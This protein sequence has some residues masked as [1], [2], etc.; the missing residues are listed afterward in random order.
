MEKISIEA[1][2]SSLK[3]DMSSQ[4]FTYND[5]KAEKNLCRI[6]IAVAEEE[7]PITK[8]EDFIKEQKLNEGLAHDCNLIVRSGARCIEEYIKSKP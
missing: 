8:F 4:F 7:Y 1:V 5:P 2:L 3:N 6:A